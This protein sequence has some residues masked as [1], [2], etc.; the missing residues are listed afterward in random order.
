MEMTNEEIR[1]NYQEAKSKKT[2]KNDKVQLGFIGLGQQVLVLLNLFLPMED[3]R[4]V[5]GC[6]VYDVKRERFARRVRNFYAE[7]GEK[8]VKVDVYEDYADLLARPDIDAVV[9]AVPDHQHALIGILLYDSRHK[10]CLASTRRH[11]YHD[12]LVLL[13]GLIK[14]LKHL[15]LVAT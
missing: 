15:L 1:K 3:V 6:D 2:S 8:K 14:A 9:I 5:A 7:K 4:V 10:V 13:P 11:L 12:T